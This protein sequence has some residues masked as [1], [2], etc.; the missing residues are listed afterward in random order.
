MKPPTLAMAAIVLMTITLTGCSPAPEPAPPISDHKP[1]VVFLV[2]HAE[3]VDSS[4]DPELSPAGHE[5][6][7]ILAGLLCSAE[8]EYVHS[9]DY[10]RTRETAAPTAAQHGLEL[11]LYDPRD[12]PV[13]VGELRETGGRHLV[14]G[15]NTTTPALVELLGGG[16]ESV[17][18]EEGEYDR[19]YIVTTGKDGS[20]SV[21]MLRYGEPYDPGR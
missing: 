17:I 11:E 8:I 20:A 18:D 10:T 5:R 6:S 4:E 15:H 21:A 7:A 9:S 12:L 19:L 14:V 16:I 3:K 2:R 1:L 13:L